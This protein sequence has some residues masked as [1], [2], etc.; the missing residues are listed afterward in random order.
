MEFIQHELDNISEEEPCTDSDDSD[1]VVLEPDPESAFQSIIGH[2]KYS[3]EIR[4][5]YL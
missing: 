2:N 1:A 3:P 4:K 5:L